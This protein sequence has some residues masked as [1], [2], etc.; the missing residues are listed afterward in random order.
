MSSIRTQIYLTREQRKKL[1]A[2]SGREG[3]TL[4]TLIREAVDGYLEE[5]P[6][7]ADVALDSTF[8]RL[9]NL[10]VPPRSEWERR[11]G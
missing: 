4:A 10:A 5:E 7:S 1:D 6:A 2:R 11:D 9:P 8:G 3:K